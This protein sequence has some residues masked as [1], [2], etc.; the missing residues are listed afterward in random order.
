MCV[1]IEL[2]KGNWEDG[3]LRK[4]YGN[5]GAAM[6]LVVFLSMK[7]NVDTAF[8]FLWQIIQGIFTV[9]L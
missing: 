4:S 7:F 9:L 6:L 3:R 2:Q 8:S 1:S 5:M